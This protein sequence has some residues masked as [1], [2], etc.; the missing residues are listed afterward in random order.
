[1]PQTT[2]PL[3]TNPFIRQVIEKYYI[4][5]AQ[6]KEHNKKVAWTVAS[7]PVELIYAMDVIPIYPENHA[8]MCGARHM[9]S[10][11]SKVA[12]AQGYSMDLCHYAL[13]DYGSILSG[14]SPIG[15]LPKP[16]MLL[17]NNCQ[18]D[19]VTKWFEILSR[20]F[21]VPHFALDVPL[22]IGRP[23]KSVIDYFLR[24]INECIEFLEVN[25]GRKMK[26]DKLEEVVDLATRASGA[27]GEIL[28]MAKNIPSP[29]TCFDAFLNMAAIVTMRGTPEAVTVY[30]KLKEE[31]AERVRNKVGA[32][33]GEKY[34][35]YW[36]NIAVWHKLRELSERFAQAK[37]SVV[38]AS[39]TNSW[40]YQFD[41]KRPTETMA[42]N[43]TNLFINLDIE[44]RIK[45]IEDLIREYSVDGMVLHSNRSCRAYSFGQYDYKLAIGDRL[46]IPSVIL[47]SDQV[48]ER[49]H[50]DSQ[51]DER[52]EAF[53]E[54]LE[55]RKRAGAA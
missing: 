54:A 8:A 38:V 44:T 25:T 32:V 41:P 29:I 33:P 45:T 7:F 49:F 48:D 22:I 53:L 23:S 14:K 18:C 2:L 26:R 37:A 13:V 47:E 12:E 17:S 36:D 34:R 43:Y 46:G 30:E 6:A 27:W 52:I 50:N 21:G 39:Y 16:D 19:T 24:Q 40:A 1:M 28:A 5:A 55:G 35:L 10:D 51:V 3:K 31:V 4:D 11:L 20:H 9:A 42:E 15:G